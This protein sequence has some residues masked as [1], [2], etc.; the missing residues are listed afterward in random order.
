MNLW[1]KNDCYPAQARREV[2]Q[3]NLDTLANNPGVFICR[4]TRSRPRVGIDRASGD[5]Q[6]VPQTSILEPNG[7]KLPGR[8]S[9]SRA[10]Q[11]KN[12]RLQSFAC[13]GQSSETRRLRR[14]RIEYVS[15]VF[16]STVAKTA[17]PPVFLA[18]NA[19]FLLIQNQLSSPFQPRNTGKKDISGR[20]EDPPLWGWSRNDGRTVP[21]S[22]PLRPLACRRLGLA[23]Y[24][25]LIRQAGLSLTLPLWP[26]FPHCP[27]SGGIRQMPSRC[28]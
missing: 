14:S 6:E 12:G 20:E 10:L 1:L 8:S 11:Y 28:P 13:M 5:L 7:E 24:P 22:E 23:S 21:R 2:L 9:R 26:L 27:A 18:V 19:R 4:G 17:F 3:F 25:L 15:F 16:R